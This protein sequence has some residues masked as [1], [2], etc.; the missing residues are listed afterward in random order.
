MKRIFSTTLKGFVCLLLLVSAGCKKESTNSNQTTP[1]AN[2]DITNNYCDGPCTVYFT[3]TSTNSFLYTWSFGTTGSG[4]TSYL[5]NPSFTYTSPGTYTVT[6]TASDGSR[7][8]TVSKTVT[9]YASSTPATRVVITGVTVEG[10]PIQTTSG[11]NWDATDATGLPDVYFTIGDA[12]NNVSLDGRSSKVNNLSFS[13][14]PSSWTINATSSTTFTLAS[15]GG[16]YVRLWDAD[17][18]DA[19]DYMGYA[20]FDPDNYSS[21]RPSSVLMTINSPSTMQ[22]RVS[23]QWLN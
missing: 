8:S 2:F 11:S 5:E 18:F 13:Q 10:F 20:G 9:I 16:I 14:L 3:N 12:N 17:D 15:I 21:T 7:T 6:L 19:D 4:N 22:V 1:V 23:L